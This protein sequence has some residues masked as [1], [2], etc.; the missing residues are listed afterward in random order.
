MGYSENGNF[1]ING[2]ITL[3]LR[4]TMTGEKLWVKRLDAEP[5]QKPYEFMAKFKQPVA[6]VGDMQLLLISGVTEKDDSDRAL[7]AALSEFYSALGKKLW[8]HID[9]EEWE[10]YLGQAADLRKEKRF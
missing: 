3:L 4:D 8:N 7:V 5:V 2:Y 1:Q 10:K 9:P 6:T